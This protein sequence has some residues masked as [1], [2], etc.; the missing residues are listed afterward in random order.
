MI[1]PLDE[2]GLLDPSPGRSTY[3]RLEKPMNCLSNR[4]STRL[5]LAIL[6][7]VLLLGVAVR[8]YRLHGLPFDR[9]WYRQIET[10]AMA[11]N[12]YEGSMNILWA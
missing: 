2:T 1:D 3:H 9:H 5:T 4:L 6:G 11:R 7:C 8:L 10:A 12:F